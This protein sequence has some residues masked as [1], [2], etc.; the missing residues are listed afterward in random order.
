MNNDIPAFPFSTEVDESKPNQFLSMGM[1]LKDYYAGQAL[2]GFLSNGASMD[3]ATHWSWMV[4]EKML[5]K[6]EEN[7]NK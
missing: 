3:N 2:V 4:A 6:R 7:K 1:S 5:K